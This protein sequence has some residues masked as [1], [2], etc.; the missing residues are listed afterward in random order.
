MG[1]I[2]GALLY[3]AKGI[4][5]HPK[6]IDA[7]FSALP[8]FRKSKGTINKGPFPAA[9]VAAEPAFVVCKRAILK[10]GNGKIAAKAFSL[11]SIYLAGEFTVRISTAG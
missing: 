7:V 11:V 8:R 6:I 4:L 3:K 5:L 9:D 2:A 1:I 10:N